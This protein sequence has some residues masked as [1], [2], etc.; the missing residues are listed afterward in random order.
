MFPEASM[1]TIASGKDSRTLLTSAEL[2][3][4]A[5]SRK[6]GPREDCTPEQGAQATLISR[7]SVAAP[8]RA[9]PVELR[10]HAIVGL[11]EAPRVREQRAIG[12]VVHRFDRGHL[13]GDRRVEILDV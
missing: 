5:S 2:S 9:L 6:V 13:V 12:R 4:R 7:I 8:V 3:M 10:P 1:I 11:E